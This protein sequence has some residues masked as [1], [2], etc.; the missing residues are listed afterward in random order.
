MALQFR[1]KKGDL[2]KAEN[3]VKNNGLITKIIYVYEGKE[4]ETLHGKRKVLKN[5][6]YFCGVKFETRK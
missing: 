5:C 3:G 1:E 4:I 2:I 6:R